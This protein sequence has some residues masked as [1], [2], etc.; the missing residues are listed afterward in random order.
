MASL[1]GKV[2]LVTGATKNMGATIAHTLAEAGA[3]IIGAGR[4]VDDGERVARE[5]R[6][7]GGS[8]M[9]I[10]TDLSREDD[11]R[12]C[13]ESGVAKFGHLD[14]L[15]NNAAPIDD[16]QS[17]ADKPI[18]Q[19]ET[20]DLE[21]VVQVGIF[22][23]AWC[24][25]YAIPHI[26]A[27]GGGAIVNI[28]SAV[29]LLGLSGQPSY[30]MIKGAMNAL[31]RQIAVEY[32]PAHIRCNAIVV[33]IVRGSVA[34]DF[35]FDHPTVGPAMRSIL[36]TRPG[37]ASDVANLTRFLASDDSAF[38]TGTII[39]CDGG[40]TSKAFLPDISAA[41]ADGPQ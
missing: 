29:S 13:I 34:T 8:A 12:N 41:F 16:L 27:A 3:T 23:T 40:T 6:D 20:A 11:V 33:G 31:T 10:R 4:S 37:Q 15:V 35:L 28:S 39:P 36:L 17:G 18:T 38:M 26:T 2:A 19:L 25:K 1:A 5:I 14:I 7:K 32:S 21:R 9:F 22:G 30:T 24:L